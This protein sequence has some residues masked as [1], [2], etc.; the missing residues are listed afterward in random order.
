MH[1]VKSFLLYLTDNFRDPL[2]GAATSVGI[3]YFFLKLAGALVL[4]VAGAFGGY[5]FS[6]LIKPRL[7][8]IFKKK[9]G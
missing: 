2:I 4:G 1:Q 9:R 8:K 7:D 5:L 6:T 3:G